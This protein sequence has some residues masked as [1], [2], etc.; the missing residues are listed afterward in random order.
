MN[1]NM[2]EITGADLKDVAKHVYDLS[3]P[4]GMGFLHYQEGGLA[5]EDAEKLIDHDDD[6]CPLSMDY[7][8]GRACKFTVFQEDGKL[9]IRKSWFDHSESDLSELLKR[10][11]VAG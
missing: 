8:H 2:I 9:F 4:Q 6:R 1:E 7:V 10:I 11:G 3:S 5:D